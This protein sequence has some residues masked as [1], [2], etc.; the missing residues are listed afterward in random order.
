MLLTMAAVTF[1]YG[2]LWRR[3]VIITQS[4]GAGQSSTVKDMRDSLSWWGIS[5]IGVFKM[6]LLEDIF[7]ERISEKRRTLL[8]RNIRRLGQHTEKLCT[9]K[10]RPSLITKVKF[11][12]CRMMQKYV[13]RKNPSSFDATYWKSQ[14]WLDKQRPWKPERL[15][16][17]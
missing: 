7:W 11:S 12:I 17:Q 5:H 10:A 16:K 8:E 9:Q 13:Y 3:A 4:I 14:G 6:P 2:C 15:M 1:K